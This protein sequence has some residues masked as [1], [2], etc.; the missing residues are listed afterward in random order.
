MQLIFI[1]C[2]FHIY[3][4]A[5][6]LEFIRNSKNIHSAF[7]VVKDMCM[8]RVAKNLNPLTRMFLPAVQHGDTPPS[9]LGSHTGNKCP[10]HGLFSATVSAFFVF[11]VGGLAD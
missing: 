11:C 7:L 4:F 2:G 6:W 3:K 10:F 5:C 8:C 1:I 9:C